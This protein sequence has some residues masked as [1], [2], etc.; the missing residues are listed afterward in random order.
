MIYSPQHPI[1]LSPH[2]PSFLLMGRANF[3]MNDT[4]YF[5]EVL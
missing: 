3:F 2:L 1:S 5:F 4:N